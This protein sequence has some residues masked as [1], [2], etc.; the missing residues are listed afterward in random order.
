[1]KKK[2][3][4]DFLMFVY[5]IVM[6][7]VIPTA[8]TMS[9][10][11]FGTIDVVPPA[12]SAPFMHINYIAGPST[13]KTIDGTPMQDCVRNEVLKYM[14]HF[15][16]HPGTQL[17]HCCERDSAAFER[18]MRESAEAASSAVA[19]RWLARSA[20]A[21]GM[22]VIPLYSYVLRDGEGMAYDMILFCCAVHVTLLDA[23][24]M[25]IQVTLFT[26]ERVLEGGIASDGCDFTI[27]M[28]QTLERVESALQAGSACDTRVPSPLGLMDAIILRG[29]F[30]ANPW[31]EGVVF[32]TYLEILRRVDERRSAAAQPP[33]AR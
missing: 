32:N 2:V 13:R 9:D 15:T 29:D 17:R 1:M 16:A 14:G 27:A 23:A 10:D 31:L 8:Y 3:E 4:I 12:S 33:A 6:C 11:M 21:T 30:S 7:L 24:V 22:V 20:G 19:D 5:C 28:L 18:S 25:S 26:F